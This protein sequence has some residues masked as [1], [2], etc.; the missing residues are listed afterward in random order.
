M[1]ETNR[2]VVESTLEGG[3]YIP[4]KD[5]KLP[6]KRGTVALTRYAI[7]EQNLQRH[8]TAWPQ[9]MIYLGLEI[10]AKADH[11]CV[12]WQ[13]MEA[14]VRALAI[15]KN[16]P[17]TVRII[18]MTNKPEEWPKG[19]GFLQARDF[20]VCSE[21][22][23]PAV[24]H[25]DPKNRVR[26][27]AFST[28]ATTAELGLTIEKQH[29]DFSGHDKYQSELVKDYI[30]G[31]DVEDR[32]LSLAMLYYFKVLERIGKQEYGNPTKSA[33]KDRTLNAIIDELGTEL[34]ADEKK[35]AE[36]INRWRH[37]KSEAHLI[38][39]GLPA[40]EELELCKKLS[41]LAILKRV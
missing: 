26:Y 27:S 23:E 17:I 29:K 2:W 18:K 12:A 5:R 11:V 16:I 24:H 6:V 36:G 41:R 34:T 39:E 33:M 13:E 40:R 10:P 38:T 37:K 9:K 25:K 32:E 1:G 30:A 28:A 15:Q 22:W 8:F 20:P 14:L 21:E 19:I 7:M 31:L 35:R 4:E 3:L